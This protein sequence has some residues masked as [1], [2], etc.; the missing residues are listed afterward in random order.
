[1]DNY[2]EEWSLIKV[3][4]NGFGMHHG[5]LPKYIQ[6]EILEQFNNGVFNILFC[7]STIVEGVNTNAQNIIILRSCTNRL[8]PF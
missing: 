4:Q 2:V 6:Q 3:L 1:M 7:T 8:K 5:K